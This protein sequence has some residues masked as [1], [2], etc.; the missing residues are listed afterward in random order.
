MTDNRSLPNEDLILVV[1]DVEEN[2]FL[3]R[4]LLTKEGY[5]VV[6]LS[7]SREV[8]Q[9]ARHLLPALILLDIQMPVIDGFE[10]CKSIKNDP[11]ICSIPVIFISAMESTADRLRGFEAGGVDYIIKPIEIDETLARV[12]S[13]I[14]IRR[15]Q[16]QLQEANDALDAQLIELTNA[17]A[18]LRE[19]ESKL[20]AF[21]SALPN[22]TFIYDAEGKYL[23]IIGNKT[24]HMVANKEEMLGRKLTE[25]LPPEVAKIKMEAIR[26]VIQTS[27]IR[28]V[29][30]QLPVQSGK[31]LW[32]EGRLALMEKHESETEKVICVTT[33][34]TDRMELQQ[35]VQTLAIQDPLTNC[36]NRR[37]FLNLAQHE[38]TIAN[39]YNRPL[40]LVILDIDHFKKINDEFGHPFGDMVLCQLV[41]TC[42]HSLR[43]SDILGRYGGEEFIILF[44][45]TA[46]P[47]ALDVA[48]RLRRTVEQTQIPSKN[49][50]ISITLSGGLACLDSTHDNQTVLQTFIEAADQAL[51][52]A[53]EEGRNR[54]VT[55]CE[56]Y[57]IRVLSK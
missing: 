12:R 1:D 14:T 7:D 45:E 42:R 48:E 4:R 21:I 54:I 31:A 57:P 2:L 39:R 34:I 51:Y 52:Q 17:Q 56:G 36:F 33:E 15:L 26:S 40:S 11:A 44:P 43:C 46:M 18:Q 55:N 35:K 16:K 32:F 53:K 28:V 20:S 8:L 29:E 23:E 37:H 24:E 30:Y 19:R 22:I 6:T 5:R 13:H 47:G 3:L 9:T 49:G 50:P 27:Q 41:E 25:F 10:V 38:I